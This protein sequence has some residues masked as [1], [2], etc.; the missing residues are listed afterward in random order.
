MQISPVVNAVT[1]AQSNNPTLPRHISTAQPQSSLPTVSS[2]SLP[3]SSRSP[4]EIHQCLFG[5]TKRKFKSSNPVS[6]K[7]LKK[8]V[9]WTHTF[10]CLPSTDIEHVPADY[11]LMA[12]NGLGKA[13]LHLSEGSSAMDIHNAILVQFPKLKACGGYELLRTIQKDYV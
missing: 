9:P 8:D 5:Y 1:V 7:K 12:A 4:Y 3:A 10:V 11:S 13:K 6:S 2:S